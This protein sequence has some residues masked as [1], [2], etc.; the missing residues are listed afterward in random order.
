MATI[1]YVAKHQNHN[2]SQHPSSSSVGFLPTPNQINFSSP[3][4]SLPFKGWY[5]WCQT[6]GHYVS[7]CP[8]FCCKFPNVIPPSQ[9]SNPPVVPPLA[10]PHL[11]AKGYQSLVPHAYAATAIDSASMGWLLTVVLLIMSS[12]ILTILSSLPL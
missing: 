9:P 3:H 6:Q 7:Q 4:S 12:M 11:I 10:Q 1:N 5:Q 8:I 2:Y